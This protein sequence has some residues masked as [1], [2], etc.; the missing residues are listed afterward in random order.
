LAINYFFGGA[1]SRHAWEGGLSALW[2]A[3]F[4]TY[5]A[6]TGDHELYEVM[7]PFIAWRALVLA[8]PIWYPRISPP[9]RDAI[10]RLAERALEAPAFDPRD[11]G[12]VLSVL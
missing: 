9:S 10:L 1:L 11:A 6:G 8:S 5:S 12:R 7:A 2:D 4:E 3:F